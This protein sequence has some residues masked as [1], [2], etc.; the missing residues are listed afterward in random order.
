MCILR[1]FVSYP[2]TAFYY[3]EHVGVYLMG[4][5]RNPKKFQFVTLLVGSFDPKKPVP[6][7]I[8]N[9]FGGT[10]NLPQPNCNPNPKP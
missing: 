6:D 4:L 1:V 7:M 2:G 9:V 10:L 8:Y 5:K 3:C